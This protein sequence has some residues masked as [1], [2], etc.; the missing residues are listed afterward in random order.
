ML[1]RDGNVFLDMK[2]LCLQPLKFSDTFL[3]GLK[4]QG[5][6]ELRVVVLVVAK[7]ILAILR[8]HS[9][10]AFDCTQDS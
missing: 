5:L 10:N 1:L 7:D 3:P 2:G 6:R 9:F 8:D 4:L